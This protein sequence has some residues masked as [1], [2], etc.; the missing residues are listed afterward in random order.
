MT[1]PFIPV[2]RSA[3]I[4]Y[5]DDSTDTSVTFVP[6]SGSNPNCLY[7]VNPDTA[8]VVAV[9]VSF[10]PL[11]TNASIPTSGAN[12]IGVVVGAASS[13]LIRIDSAYQ[14]GNLYVSGVGDSA[15]GNIFVTPG[16][17]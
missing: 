6:E 7:I 1:F 11:D 12:G 4:A 13:V 17:L 3:I 5:A 14:G 8:N 9:N 16:I 10:D 15:T 2:N